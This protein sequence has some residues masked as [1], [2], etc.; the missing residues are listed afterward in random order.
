MNPSEHEIE[1]V[2]YMKDFV[3][4]HICSSVNIVIGD[5]I[6]CYGTRYIVTEREIVYDRVYSSHIKCI[7]IF[8]KELK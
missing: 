6:N 8:C 1:Y 3:L 2:L 4:G 5:T 7:N